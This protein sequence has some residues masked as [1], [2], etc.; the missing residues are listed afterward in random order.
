MGRSRGRAPRASLMES[1]TASR[2]LTVNQTLFWKKGGIQLFLQCAKHYCFPILKISK[3][4]HIFLC[5]MDIKFEIL[6]CILNAVT[7]VEVE[8]LFTFYSKPSSLW[9]CLFSLTYLYC[10]YIQYS[11]YICCAS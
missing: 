11:P 8:I 4:Q 1:C 7:S 6:P 10:K 9:T 5:L 3:T 2:N